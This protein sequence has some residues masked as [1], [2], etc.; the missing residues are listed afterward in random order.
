MKICFINL[1]YT[2]ENG[3]FKPL[4]RGKIDL[5]VEGGEL[6]AAG[7]GCPFNKEGY[8]NAYTDTYYGR[9]M[10]VVKATDGVVKVTANGNG[11]TGSCEIIAE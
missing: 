3:N 7:H 6:L 11:L 8:N 4:E 2:D 5:Q 1:A 10:A 9:A